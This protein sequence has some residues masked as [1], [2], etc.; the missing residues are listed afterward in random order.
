MVK[1][2][3]GIIGCGER[4][5]TLVRILSGLEKNI[6]IVS[7]YDPDKEVA[8]NFA[9]TFCPD[10]RVHKNYHELLRDSKVEWVM[11]GS[12]N[13][14]HKE[15][16]IAS[17]KAGK[18][19]FCEKPIATTLD[20]HLEI[21]KA[22]LHYKKLFMI[23]FT[24]RYSPHY[25][26]IKK[27]IEG[28]S[29]GKIVSLEF[30]E[31]LDFNHGGL[32][33]G[34]WRRLRKNAGPHVLE[35]CS[36]DVDIVNWIVKSKVTKVASFGGCNFFLPENEYHIERIGKD[37]NGK[38]AYFASLSP[39]DLNPF[40]SDKDIVDNQV[41][42]IEF[43]NGVR[44][45]FH[46]NLNSG[47]PERR[48]YI[49]GTEGAVRSDVLTGKITVKRIGFEQTEKDE[50]TEAKGLHGGGELPLCMNL[51]EAMT[52]GTVP[53][54]GFEDGLKSAV[55]CFGIDKAMKTGSVVE[56]EPFLKKI[57]FR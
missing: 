30:N 3:I 26:K 4:I 43:E 44:A 23:G 22:Y 8:G 17:F 56:M 54:T 41:A 50:S 20:D 10:S 52:R 6:Q 2:G 35:K 47:I 27:I 25:Q 32:I 53:V 51:A 15:Q 9:K 1:T 21:K 24:L 18:N 42:I 33:M 38:E 55:I 39:S 11:I 34:G 45:S 36:H 12:W 14:F 37:K 57:D 48:L 46:T 19:V 49:L 5:R 40:V 7:V 31:T 16:I 29:I 13:C 28:R